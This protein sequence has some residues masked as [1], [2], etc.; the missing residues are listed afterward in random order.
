MHQ[1]P[2]TQAKADLMTGEPCDPEFDPDDIAAISALSSAS[3][4]AID[5]AILSACT[6]HWQKV[7]YVVAVAM[8]VHPDNYTDIPDIYYAERVRRLVSRGFL[9][10]QGNLASMRFSEVRVGSMGHSEI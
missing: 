3:I 2:D 6:H 7:A 10:G 8:D 9:E 5:K 4:E 1:C